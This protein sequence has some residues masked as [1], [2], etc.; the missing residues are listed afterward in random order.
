MYRKILISLIAFV[1]FTAC[2]TTKR[3]EANTAKQSH[4]TDS[5][6]L[7]P[8]EQQPIIHRGHAAHASHASHASH[9][10]SR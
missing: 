7:T 8:S 1:S 9:Y 3:S 10:S 6:I 4:E 5:L 2:A